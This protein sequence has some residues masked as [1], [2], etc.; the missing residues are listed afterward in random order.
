MTTE[1]ERR[2][3]CYVLPPKAFEM[4]PCACG[5]V[6]TQWSEFKRHLWCEACK[7]D[8]E[9][10]HAGLLDGPV[11]SQVARMFGIVFDRVILATGK[12][13]RFDVE[14]GTWVT[15]ESPESIARRSE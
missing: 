5:N 2:E 4:A 11:L 6:D 1:L 3:W 15:E 10:K 7:I 8:F 14:V 12:V 9:P 13:E